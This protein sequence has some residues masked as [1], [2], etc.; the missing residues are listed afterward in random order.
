MGEGPD[1]ECHGI[2]PR[3]NIPDLPSVVHSPYIPRLVSPLA[4][5]S[6][7]DDDASICKAL[8]RVL[9]SSGYDVETH[10]SGN[11]FLQS[12]RDH[13]PDCVVLDLHMPEMTGFEVQAQ[14]QSCGIHVPV[15]VITGQATPKAYQRAMTSGAFAYVCKPVDAMDLLAAINGALMSQRT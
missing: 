8:R 9:R 10:A 6:I 11:G 15:V 3:S 7:V 12:I 4:L 2:G 5:I 13:I 14:L 1:S